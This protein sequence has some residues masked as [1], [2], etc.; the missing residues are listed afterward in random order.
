[1]FIYFICS[2]TQKTLYIH[3]RT[4]DSLDFLS[5]IV[6]TPQ[7]QTPHSFSNT[8][9]PSANRTARCHWAPL[10]PRPVNHQLSP[11]HRQPPLQPLPVNHW[12]STAH[13]QILTVNIPP[14]AR[15]IFVG[16]NERKRLL[17]SL[18]RRGENK[19][20]AINT[21]NIFWMVR[22]GKCVLLRI[23]VLVK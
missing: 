9:P 16:F 23:N 4:I 18:R 8:T 3:I 6:V 7:L 14:S 15:A 22:S 10:Q 13:R 19:L 20:A 11:S 1:M 2:Y 5:L 12:P 21:D 17:T